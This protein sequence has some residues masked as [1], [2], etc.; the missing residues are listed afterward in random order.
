MSHMSRIERSRKSFTN[1]MLEIQIL[2]NMF[3]IAPQQ[4]HLQIILLLYLIICTCKKY[5]VL[6]IHSRQQNVTYTLSSYE[7]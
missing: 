7:S 6:S 4:R 5:T 1:K 3:S 2:M